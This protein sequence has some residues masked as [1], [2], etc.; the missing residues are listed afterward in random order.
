MHLSE[1]F[2]GSS[3]TQIYLQNYFSQEPSIMFLTKSPTKTAFLKSI[4]LEEKPCDDE[5]NFTILFDSSLG[6][7]LQINPV[8]PSRTFS[9]RPPTL[10]VITGLLK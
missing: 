8:W 10:V 4:T 9:G 6:V 3:S 2:F 7:G 5:K 1:R